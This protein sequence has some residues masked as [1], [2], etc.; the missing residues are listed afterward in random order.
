[1]LMIDD[2]PLSRIEIRELRT[3]LINSLDVRFRNILINPIFLYISI[4][5]RKCSV[6]SNNLLVAKASTDS[7]NETDK[8]MLSQNLNYLGS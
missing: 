1:M 2:L 7:V 4:I 3:E 8:S 6:S 5:T